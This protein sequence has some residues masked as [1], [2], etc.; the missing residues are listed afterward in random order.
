MR[1]YTRQ[2]RS[3][4]E[5]QNVEVSSLWKL[6]YNPS[7][8]RCDDAPLLPFQLLLCE[9]SCCSLVTGEKFPHDGKCEL[10]FFRYVPTHFLN[11][12]LSSRLFATELVSWCSPPPLICQLSSINVLS[13]FAVKLKFYVWFF[14]GAGFHKDL[15]QYRKL[16]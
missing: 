14:H 10:L 1:T 6:S 2:D 11:S 12:V 8:W 4:L 7:P 9:L 3:K 13:Y 16:C 5:P 15:P